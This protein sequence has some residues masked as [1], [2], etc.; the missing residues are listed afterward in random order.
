MFRFLALIR[1][2][3]CNI[4]LFAEH[5]FRES[6]G[7]LPGM[8][9]VYGERMPV[10]GGVESIVSRAITVHKNRG[11]PQGDFPGAETNGTKGFNTESTEC[12]EKK[13]HQN[14]FLQN[15][16]GFG[17]VSVKGFDDAGVLLL[18][19]AALELEREGE[20]A[21]VESEIFRKKSEA[22][23]GFVLRKMD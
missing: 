3:L 16:A 23:D 19:D 17:D 11:G 10:S 8:I 1:A 14:S 20:G 5:G 15:R 22:L 7:A 21:I 6:R 12:T 4:P 13:K 2:S 9:R 18:D